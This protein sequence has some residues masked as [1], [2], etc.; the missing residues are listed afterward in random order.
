MSE[1]SFQFWHIESTPYGYGFS[2]LFEKWN[3]SLRIETWNVS[4]LWQEHL[5]SIF[6]SIVFNCPFLHCS[7]SELHTM[8]NLIVWTLYGISIIYSKRKS[9]SSSL[10]KGVKHLILIQFQRITFDKR[11]NNR[12][13]KKK[14][15]VCFASNTDIHCGNKYCSNQ[16]SISNSIC[17]IFHLILEQIIW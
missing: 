13:M 5:S 15:K 9:H 17:D 12:K 14:P 11:N 7:P 2:K 3:C 16:S 6:Q 10:E 1:I 8:N 4:P